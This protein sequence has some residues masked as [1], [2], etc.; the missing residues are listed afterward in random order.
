MSQE[1]YYCTSTAAIMVSR[2]TQMIQKWLRGEN[3]RWPAP[4]KT[5]R[6]GRELRIPVEAVKDLARFLVETPPGYCYTKPDVCAPEV[7]WMLTPEQT[8]DI[9]D[10]TLDDLARWREEGVG[11]RPREYWGDEV[12]YVRKE[13]NS[14][15]RKL[16]A[17]EAAARG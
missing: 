12:R 16:E 5:H 10:A 3:K 7:P 9:L 13:V 15:R 1:R 8:A 17:R 2:S 6:V 14:W 11:P 4:P